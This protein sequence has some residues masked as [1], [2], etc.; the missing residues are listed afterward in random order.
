MAS[1]RCSTALDLKLSYA[2]VAVGGLESSYTGS[3]R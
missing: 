2:M 3:P 1:V